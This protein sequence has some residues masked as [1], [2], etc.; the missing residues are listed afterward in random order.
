MFYHHA[1]FK[2]LR[3]SVTLL[4]MDHD[5]KTNRNILI[6]VFALMLILAGFLLKFYVDQKKENSSLRIKLLTMASNRKQPTTWKQLTTRTE[7]QNQKQNKNQTQTNTQIQTPPAQSSLAEAEKIPMADRPLEDLVAELN[8]NMRSVQAA[9]AKDLD[10]NIELAEEIISREPGSYAAY[11]AKLISMLIKEGKYNQ[12][13]DDGEVN[14]VLESMAGFDVTTDSVA[15]REAALLSNANNQLMIYQDQLRSVSQE[16]VTLDDQIESLDPNSPEASLLM[17]QRQELL[18]QEE[19]ASIQ[20]NQF[21]NTVQTSLA[22]DSYLNEE[23]VE[24]PFMRALAKNDFDTVEDDASAFIEQ[25]PTS[26]S[27]YYYLIRALEF[28]GRNEEIPEIIASSQLSADAQKTLQ[29]RLD[30]NRSNDP[31]K[32]WQRL[33][34]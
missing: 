8:I 17:A 6:A 31:K 1:P 26:V 28:Q 2:T 27:G 4:I 22:D 33:N 9:A 14:S 34:F 13:L 7:T 15:R 29:D 21:Q 19:A 32:Y 11:K 25:F 10:H 3:L 18:A 24:I 12:D 16:R 23:I 30:Q 20:L 5:I